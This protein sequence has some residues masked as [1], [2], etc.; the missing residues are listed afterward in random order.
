M[1]V[2]NIEAYDAEALM[3]LVRLLQY[4]N[5]LLKEKLKKENISYDEVILLKR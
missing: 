3:K 2:L 5:K 1:I 4:E